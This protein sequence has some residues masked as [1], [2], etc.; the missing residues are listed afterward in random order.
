MGTDQTQLVIL[1]LP[2]KVQH[3]LS[4]VKEASCPACQQEGAQHWQEGGTKAIWW[5]Q[6]KQMGCYA[7]IHSV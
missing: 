6:T 2:S 4:K 5:V 1:K 3:T 7:Y